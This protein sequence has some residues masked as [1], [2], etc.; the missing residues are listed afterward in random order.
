MSAIVVTHRQKDI[1]H[2][3]YSTLVVSKVFLKGV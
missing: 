3:G 1:C 2:K